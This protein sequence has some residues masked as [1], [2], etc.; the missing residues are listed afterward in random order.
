MLGM[1]YKYQTKMIVT[2]MFAQQLKKGDI[3]QTIYP[4]N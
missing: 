4:C 3:I 2:F 1:K